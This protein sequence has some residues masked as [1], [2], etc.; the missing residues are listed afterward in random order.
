MEE[1]ETV[2]RQFLDTRNVPTMN[3]TDAIQSEI[4]KRQTLLH[5]WQT[6][7]ES[8]QPLDHEWMDRSTLARDLKTVDIHSCTRICSGIVREIFREISKK[9]QEKHSKEKGRT[10]KHEVIKIL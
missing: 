6:K 5:V 2:T 10:K 4:L 8:H 9:E 7:T 1:I 3:I